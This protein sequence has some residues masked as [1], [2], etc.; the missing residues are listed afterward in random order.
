MRGPVETG[1]PRDSSPAGFRDH[2]REPRAIATPS[3]ATAL[4]AFTLI[5]VA[6]AR[7]GLL[8]CSQRRLGSFA[9]TDRRVIRGRAALDPVQ[10]RRA[11]GVVGEESFSSDNGMGT[12]SADSESMPFQEHSDGGA[13]VVTLRAELCPQCLRRS[14]KPRAAPPRDRCSVRTRTHRRPDRS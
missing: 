2:H 3:S 10:H 6:E 14:R 7:A 11:V 13:V 12:C 9:G 1:F 4:E 8:V 5:L